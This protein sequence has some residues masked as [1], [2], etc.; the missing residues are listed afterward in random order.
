MVD[1]KLRV[2]GTFLRPEQC[3]RQQVSSSKVFLVFTL[4][5]LHELDARGFL[6]AF[7]N[8]V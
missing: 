7:E 5:G 3:D 2:G 1:S 4:R 8:R 6:V